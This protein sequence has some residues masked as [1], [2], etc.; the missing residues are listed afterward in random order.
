MDYTV[1]R[2]PALAAL[3]R[4][5]RDPANC[6]AASLAPGEVIF[7]WNGAPHGRSPQRGPTPKRAEERRK[8]LRCRLRR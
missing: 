8:L 6:Y 5:I 7:V 1:E 4:L 2:T 3:D